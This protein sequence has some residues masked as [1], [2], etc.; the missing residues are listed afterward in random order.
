MGPNLGSKN[1]D[2][3]VCR[4]LCVPYSS[5]SCL[6]WPPVIAVGPEFDSHRGDIFYS[7][8]EKEKKRKRKLAGLLRAHF[9]AWVGGMRNMTRADEG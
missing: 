3:Y 1:R 6:L 9:A 7:V 5:R 4:F 8:C 2:M